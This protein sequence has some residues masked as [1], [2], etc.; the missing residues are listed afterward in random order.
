MP[1]KPMDVLESSLDDPISVTLKDG[2]TIEGDLR[3]FDQHLN[4]VVDDA[5]T[6]SGEGTTVIRGDNVVTINT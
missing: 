6:P 2:T 4:L 5:E 1:D 3:G